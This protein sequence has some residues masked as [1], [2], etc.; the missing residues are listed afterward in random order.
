M[1]AIEYLPIVLLVLVFTIT[2]LSEKGSVIWKL[3]AGFTV[4]MMLLSVLVVVYMVVVG[5]QFAVNSETP[6][7]HLFRF[8]VCF[9]AVTLIL[10]YFN[11]YFKEGR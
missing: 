3:Y 9:V 5:F 1:D 7:P 11:R 8:A 2:I 10:M 6:E 4:V